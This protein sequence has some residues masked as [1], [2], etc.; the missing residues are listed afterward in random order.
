MLGIMG[1]MEAEDSLWRAPKGAAER[2]RVNDPML[3]RT[4]GGMNV[5]TH[6]AVFGIVI[7]KF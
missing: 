1:E 7:G 3:K 6:S 5:S 2:R 4:N